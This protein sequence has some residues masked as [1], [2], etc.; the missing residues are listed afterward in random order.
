MKWASAGQKVWE[1]RGVWITAPT[2]AAL[3]LALRWVG[4]LQPF[5]W[6]ALDQYFQWRPQEPIDQR[7]VI[8]GVSESDIKKVGR[9]PVPDG[10]FAQVIEKI[11]TSK[12]RAI[13]LD[14]YRDLPVEPGHKDLVKV[15]QT[16]PNLIG[17]ENKVED[18]APP[19]EL[20]KR[21]QVGVNDVVVDTDGTLR[22]GMLFLSTPEG[23]SLPSL[24]LMLAWMYLEAEKVTPEAGDAAGNMK[25][26][27][28][29]FVP[30]EKNDGGYVKADDGGYQT[31]LNY[32]GPAKTFRTVSMYDVLE[33]RVPP[34]LF[35]DRIV[36]LGPQA[37]S[38]NDLIK[39]P[40][41]GGIGTTPERT[42]GVEIQANLIS[43]V[44]SSALSDRPL[45]KTWPD[46]AEWLWIV[47][48]SFVGATL[49]W[50]LRLPQY[51][52]VAVLVAGGVLV[53][54]TIFAFVT[55][56]WWIPVAPA[57]LA[58]LGSSVAITGYIV[59]V[60]R[61]DRQTVMNLFGRHV[62]PQIAEA[63]WRGRHELLKE[64]RL[65]ARKMTATVVFTDLKDFSTITEANDPEVLMSWL[66]EYM[67]AM[68]QIVL[69]HGGV[70]DKFIGDAIMAV[71][72]VPIP[73]TTEEEIAK[74]AQQ[75]VHCA[76]EMAAALK[77]LNQKWQEQGRP[78]AAMRVG[79]S[80]GSVLVGS[81]GSSQRV[82][83][84]TI[85]DSVNVAARLESYD[86]SLDGGLCRILINEE[87]YVYN[88]DKVSTEFIGSVQLKG[89]Q[90]P[91]K[92]YQ[93]FLK[94]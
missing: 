11:K 3:L 84:T 62:T 12:P 89:R 78:Q 28:T 65:L 70:V 32:R 26:G 2:V 94:E 6:A 77:V 23:E 41:S 76:L 47:G 4:L 50:V 31:L 21:N 33:N 18:I 90:Q 38:F 16:T 71:F 51:T 48:W 37:T 61:E 40:Y 91:A 63:I 30:F 85:G 52:I 75:A 93:V 82:D 44:L 67:E 60:E 7:V 49:S 79:I 86:K 46:R 53:G 42:P 43:Q 29:L 10:V 72:G 1:W 54:G 58:L 80:T 20:K 9:F 69:S 8:V 45:I 56:G 74:E 83:Y 92:V 24:G 87:T 13:G 55:A 81:L 73:R 5:E 35:R 59:S 19:P 39:T 27:K 22:R 68:T 36:L 66:N 17:I 64:G 88:Q 34:E 15:F 57:A 14:F 25:L